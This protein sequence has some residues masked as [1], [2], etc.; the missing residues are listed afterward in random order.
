MVDGDTDTAV[1]AEESIETPAAVVPASSLGKRAIHGVFWT[2]ASYGGGQAIRFLSN[3]LLS[4]LLVP[5]YF[6]LMALL[7]TLLM[8]LSLFSDFGLAPSVIRRADGDDPEFL[9]AVWTVQVLR[10]CTLWLICEAL[11]WPVSRF[12][13][14]PR[15]YPLLSAAAFSLLIWGFNCTSFMTLARHIATAKLARVEL[16]AQVIQLVVTL[17]IALFNP[18]VWALVIGRFASDISRL[19]IGFSLIPGY[20]NRFVWNPRIVQELVSFGKWVLAS[21]AATFLASQADR[22]VLGRLV[23]LSTLG[24]YSITF[25]IAD[26]PRQVILSFAGQVALPIVSKISFLPRVEFRTRILRYRR[27][28]LLFGAFTLAIVVNFSDILLLRIYDH[29]Y[30]DAAWMAPVLALGLW[31]TILYNTTGTCLVALGKM[32]YT[33]LGY[34]LTAMVILLFVPLTFHR[35]GMVGAVWTVAFSDVPVYFAN[36]LGLSREALSPLEQDLQMTMVFVGC[37]GLLFALR[38]S[39]G[40]PW[41]HPVA[42]H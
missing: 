4:R 20:R 36:L 7:N 16:T 19:I 13:N 9:N 5:Q 27:I 40:F 35:W 17:A 18:S 1:I 41:P 33:L 32:R 21:T 31:H 42:L 8:G 25:A 29:R 26:V 15:L 10:G 24:L 3:L 14:Q 11:S 12:Y 28:V 37:F 30:H 39:L 38:V 22:L 6:G 34:V 2:I 23:S